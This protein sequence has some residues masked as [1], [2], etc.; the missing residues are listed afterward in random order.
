MRDQQI[1]IRRLVEELAIIHEIMNNH[2]GMTQVCTRWVK[3]L[4]TSIQRA[5]R[6]DCCPDRSNSGQVFSFYRNRR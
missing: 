5:N 3:K 6:V 4:L 2:M 1:S